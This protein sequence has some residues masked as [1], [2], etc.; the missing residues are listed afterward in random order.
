MRLID[1]DALYK[2]IKDYNSDGIIR[3]LV[4]YTKEI[5]DTQPT[6]D[7]VP[8]E[9]IEAMRNDIDAIDLPQ[10]YNSAEEC[11]AFCQA[12][13][14]VGEVLDEYFGGERNEKERNV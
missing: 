10:R 11:F 1:A 9:T 4:K 14:Q 6:I 12:L 5:L 13:E 8:M 7:A 3:F 2:R